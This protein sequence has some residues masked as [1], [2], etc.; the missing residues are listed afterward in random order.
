MLEK[1]EKAFTNGI[2]IYLNGEA[3]R[4]DAYKF[5]EE[6]KDDYVETVYDQLISLMSKTSVFTSFE[7][8]ISSKRDEYFT[9]RSDLLKQIEQ[10]LS[11]KNNVCLCGEDGSGKTSCVIEYTHRQFELN[12]L[13]KV[14]WFNADCE[15]KIIGSIYK[16]ASKIEKNESNI[17]RLT[18]ILLNSINEVSNEVIL[19]FDDVEKLSNITNIINLKHVKAPI[20]ITSRHS[21]F[22]NH[23]KVIPVSSYVTNEANVHLKALMPLLTSTDIEKILKDSNQLY[24]YKINEI[25][26]ILKNDTSITINEFCKLTSSNGQLDFIIKKLD[27]DSIKLLQCLT[28]LDPDYIP[29]EFLK[30]LKMQ[31]N[32]KQ[33]LQRLENFNLVSILNANSPKFGIRFQKLVKN[34]FDQF[35]ELNNKTFTLREELK[36]ELLKALDQFFP[37]VNKNESSEWEQACTYVPHVLTFLNKIDVDQHKLVASKL[38]DKLGSYYF[39]IEQNYE[40][41][42][43][44]AEKSLKLRQKLFQGENCDIAQSLYSIG[45][46][47]EYLGNDKKALHYKVQSLKMRKKLFQGDH[48]DIAKT[49][50]SIGLVAFELERYLAFNY[51]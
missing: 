27:N 19:V 8:Q 5:K 33:S 21:T 18:Q 23:F 16:Y 7:Y 15:V 34:S 10:N 6:S 47:H 37:L 1:L 49:L 25:A 48:P 45:I 38:L 22:E 35:F 43:N 42:L 4:I 30:L 20:L 2:N 39:S 41:S 50:K 13:K 36:I 12:Y 44:A 24:P 31:N 40:L 28:F 29:L 46:S 17:T 9:G 14:Y 32:V 11:E 26:G 51:M 3:M